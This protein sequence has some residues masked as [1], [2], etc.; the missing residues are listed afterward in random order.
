MRSVDKKRGEDGYET[1]GRRVGNK[2][3]IMENE[4]RRVGNV[5]RMVKNKG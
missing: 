2:E 5:G 3:R 4:E 1:W